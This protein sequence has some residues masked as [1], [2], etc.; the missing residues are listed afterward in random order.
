MLP[1]VGPRYGDEVIERRL[2]S[3][4]D[5]PPVTQRVPR[6]AVRTVDDV[7]GDPAESIQGAHGAALLTRQKTRS[8][9]ERSAVARRDSRAVRVR[10]I[11]QQRIGRRLRRGDGDRL[12]RFKRLRQQR[13]FPGMRVKHSF[14][15]SYT[16]QYSAKQSICLTIG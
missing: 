5:A 9:L 13:G 4:R 11:E 7:V 15:L 6:L 16:Y 2:G 12:P 14:G 1:R 10:S 8:A 3:Q